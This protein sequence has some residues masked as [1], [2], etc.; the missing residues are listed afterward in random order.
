M[1]SI[2][3]ALIL[4][5]CFTATIIAQPCT[6]DTSYTLLNVG[7]YPESVTNG[8]PGLP[9]A[10]LNQFYDLTMTAVVPDSI[11]AVE[12]S[13]TFYP[14]DSIIL[15]SDTSV[16]MNLPPGIELECDPSDC[17][18]IGGGYFCN[19]ISG[20]P[21]MLGSWNVVY[22]VTVY[23]D[24]AGVPFGVQNID[25]SYQIIV[26]PADTN[27]VTS[28]ESF[29]EVDIEFYPNP[30][31]EILYISNESRN[32]TNLSIF[33]S[34][35]KIMLSQEISHGN[36]SLDLSGFKP[37]LYNVLLEGGENGDK[38]EVKRFIKI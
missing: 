3:T 5:F 25:S 9:D 17:R 15:N 27:C 7:V 2:L 26:H 1:K 8:G 37:G 23:I 22:D 34:D 30:A 19:R 4:L 38:A 35:G 36:T 12:G 21:T 10:C 33:G 28:V 24:F 16:L 32:F 14:I 29:Q 6:P 18:Y 31:N 13:G 11:E 20:T